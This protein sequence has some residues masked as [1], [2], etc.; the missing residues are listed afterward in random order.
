MGG[1]DCRNTGGETKETSILHVL[2]SF[3]SVKENG[4]GASVTKC[5]QSSMLDA[6]HRG[7]YHRELCTFL[8]VRNVF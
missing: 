4:F 5:Q 2:F 7:V 1:G 3:F 6:G 8:Y